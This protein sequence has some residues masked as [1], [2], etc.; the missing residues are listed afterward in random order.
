MSLEETLRKMEDRLNRLENTSPEGEPIPDLP[1]QSKEA[2]KIAKENSD[3][4]KKLEE[5]ETQRN[6]NKKV[7]F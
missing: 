5:A 3:R 1:D 2:L 4:I 7:Q 6:L